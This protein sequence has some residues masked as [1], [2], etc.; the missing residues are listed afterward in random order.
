MQFF[1]FFIFFIILHIV[2]DN[3]FFS[4]RKS[5]WAVPFGSDTSL[6][7]ELGYQCLIRRVIDHYGQFQNGRYK[8]HVFSRNVLL[9]MVFLN[10]ASQ[11]R[12]ACLILHF[13]VRSSIYKCW[14]VIFKTQTK[15]AARNENVQNFTF[16][17]K[18]FRNTRSITQ[19]KTH[20][21]CHLVQRQLLSENHMIS[22]WFVINQYG[23]F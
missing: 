22:T 1:K 8:V 3:M 14:N 13:I 11:A 23:R 5:P 21:R 2:Y 7:S 4:M 9:N 12:F 15:M 18:Y 10:F 16:S 19:E 6:K 20:D 17:C